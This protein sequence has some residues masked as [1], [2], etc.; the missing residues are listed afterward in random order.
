MLNFDDKIYEHE[1]LI[2]QKN[3]KKNKP[4]FLDIGCG[5]GYLL[6]KL[7]NKNFDVYGIEH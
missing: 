1:L 6:N 7:N 3:I 5:N 2:L 4:K